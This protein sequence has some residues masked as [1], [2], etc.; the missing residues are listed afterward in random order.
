[1]QLEHDIRKLTLKAGADLFGIANLVPARKAILEQW[2]ESVARFPCAIAI[3]IALPDSIID[4]LPQQTNA[5]VA[6]SYRRVYDETNLRLDQIASQVVERVQTAG[7]TALAVRASHNVDQNRHYGIFSHKMAAYLAGLGWI[8]KSSLL[9]TPEMGPR[10][11]WATV[12]TDAPLAETGQP[13]DERCGACVKCVNTC[14]AG[15]F[16]GR[17]FQVAEHRD[18]RFS[19]K[20]CAAYMIGRR[21]EFDYAVLCGL[22][23]SVCPHGKRHGSK[24]KS[25]GIIARS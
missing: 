4:L 20:K 23:V 9:I 11:R 22:C 6:R 21:Q 15:A 14:P 18:M 13:A 17:A 16:T 12:L 24:N 3:G 8:G 5:D 1:L 10:I 19:A 2:G 25:T 7:F